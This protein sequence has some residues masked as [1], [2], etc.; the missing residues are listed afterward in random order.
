MTGGGRGELS[1]NTFLLD[2]RS[3]HRLGAEV[4]SRTDS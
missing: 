3:C 4:V 2:D 1:R